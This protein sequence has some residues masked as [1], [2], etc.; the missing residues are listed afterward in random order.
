M[1][2]VLLSVV[3]AVSTTRRHAAALELNNNHIANAPEMFANRVAIFASLR[4]NR[5]AI[6]ASVL[7]LGIE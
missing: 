2:R 5:V 7:K 3:S 4:A 6:F 1:G